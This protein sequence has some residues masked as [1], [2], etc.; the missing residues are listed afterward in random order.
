M[1]P[2]GDFERRSDGERAEVTKDGGVDVLT[3]E[4]LWGEPVVV[5][6]TDCQ[7]AAGGFRAAR[8]RRGRRWKGNSACTRVF[9]AASPGQWR[10]DS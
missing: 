9:S 2:F 8:A 10:K 1:P 7:F 6:V 3:V 4:G 5:G